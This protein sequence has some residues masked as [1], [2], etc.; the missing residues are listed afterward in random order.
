[1]S[2]ERHLITNIVEFNPKR[3]VKK[4]TIAPFIDMAALPISSRDIDEVIEKV[5]KSGGAKFANGDTLFARITPCLENGKTAK[6][7]GLPINTNAFG[8][9]EFIVMAA[10]EPEYDEN[11]IYYLARLPEFRSYAKAR[12]EGTSGRQRVSWQSLAEF[13]YP[14]PDKENRKLAGNFLRAMDDKITLNT[15]TNQT[16]EG[17]AQAI[18]KSWF[19]DFD[20]VKAK[21]N[22]E[23]PEGIDASTASLFPEKLVESELGLIPEGWQVRSLGDISTFQNGF[24]FKSKELTTDASAGTHKVF[25]MGNI[26]KG[27]GFNW[28]GSKDHFDL[29]STPKLE[30]Y[31]IK[32]GDLLMSMTDMKNN[33]ALLGYTALMPVSDV[34]L[35]NQRVGLIRKS[36]KHYLNY[37]FLYYQT[38]ANGFL[39]DIRSRANSGVQVNLSTAGIKDTL[40]VVPPKEIHE[41]FDKQVR[42]YLE[43]MFSNDAQSEELAKLR[44]LLLPKLLSGEIDLAETTIL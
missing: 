38:N 11:Y 26:R 33:V 25:K 31:L 35:V 44:D 34:F 36:E 22:G 24:A 3:T 21:M 1:M 28:H 39:T 13:E 20:P 5:F 30:R 43:M 15:Q 32:K 18:F 9:T 10:K 37:P 29:N 27:G 19:V 8:S 23:Q 6:V 2:F 42:S 40:L 7:S 17:M 14:Y 16:L 41:I 12:M 4:G